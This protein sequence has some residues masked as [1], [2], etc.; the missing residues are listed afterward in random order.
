MI[1]TYLHKNYLFFE[2]N[3]DIKKFAATILLQ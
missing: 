3:Y 1:H 2:L